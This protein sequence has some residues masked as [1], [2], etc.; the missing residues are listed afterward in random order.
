[1]LYTSIHCSPQT[2]Q[3]CPQT[4]PVEP[5]S[6][7]FI[8][9]SSVIRTIFDHCVLQP[10]HITFPLSS[11]ANQKYTFPAVSSLTSTSDSFSVHVNCWNTK[12][13][14]SPLIHE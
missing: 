2:K 10:W 4:A 12:A 13:K 3:S 9:L 11:F 1:M 8:K 14:F 6:K 5:P 7:P